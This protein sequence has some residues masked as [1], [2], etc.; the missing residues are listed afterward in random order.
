MAVG[1]Q[2]AMNK[3]W[4]AINVG[5]ILTSFVNPQ[6]NRQQISQLPADNFTNEEGSIV[7]ALKRDANAGTNAQYSVN[8]GD[9]LLGFWLEMTLTAPDNQFDF[10][11][12][13]F[14]KWEASQKTP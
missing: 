8:E 11:Y 10:I 1:Y 5:D 6:S 12:L 14:V 2:S 7:A 4:G 3:K 9:P 13:P